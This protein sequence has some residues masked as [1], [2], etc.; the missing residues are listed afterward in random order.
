M[1]SEGSGRKRKS[2]WSDAPVHYTSSLSI[3]PKH[4]PAGLTIEQQECL[5]IRVRVEEL[6]KKM[7][8][9]DLDMEW[10]RENDPDPEPIYDNHGKRINTRDQRRKDGMALERQLLVEEA[11]T[12]NPNFKPPADY[13]TTAI[14]R[15]KKLWIPV[16]K[17][18][19]YNFFGL[20]VGPRGTH[21]R[22]WS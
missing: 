2:R 3:L 17:Y 8:I 18:P 13:S 1:H 7:A 16:E 15:V 4:L 12:M 9:N 6:T 14:K 22:D 5:S 21:R 11:F 10:F 19:N 20:I